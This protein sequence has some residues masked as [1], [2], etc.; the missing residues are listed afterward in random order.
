MRLRWPRWLSV[1]RARRLVIVVGVLAVGYVSLTFAQVL[2]ASGEDDRAS[3][4]A[5]VVL[6]AAQYNGEPSPVLAARLDHAYALWE[7][8]VA[9]IVV[10]TGS[11]RPGDQFTEGYAGFEYLRFAGIPEDDILVITDGDSSWEQL[12]ATARVLRGEDLDSVVLVSDPYH[13]LRLRQISDQ[14]G[15]DASVSSTD[16]GSSI[17]QLVRET[18]AVS[19]GRVLGYRRVDNWLGSVG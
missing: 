2:E 10:T 14:V 19:L 3:A 15:L 6:G 7:A 12:A 11:N 13:A 5:I 1:R 4:D 9:P 17:R 16:G 18:A 8:G